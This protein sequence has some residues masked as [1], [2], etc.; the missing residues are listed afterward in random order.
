VAGAAAGP[1]SR[2]FPQSLKLFVAGALIF[3]LSASP[4]RAG[5][6]LPPSSALF[7]PRPLLLFQPS[8]VARS[9]ASAAS[10]R[11][12]PRLAPASSHRGL[13]FLSSA[14]LPGDPPLCCGPLSAG[15]VLS[16]SSAERCEVAVMAPFGLTVTAIT[17]R[18]GAADVAGPRAAATS[19]DPI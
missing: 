5:A 9:F 11:L 18:P 17:A 19:P 12:S 7:D 15:D 4:P 13:P 10:P 16:G 2:L 14:G 3:P 1:L 6:L 8:V